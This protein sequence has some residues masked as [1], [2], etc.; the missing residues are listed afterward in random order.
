M[1]EHTVDIRKC[2]K[3]IHDE[4]RLAYY[5]V[6]Q[7]VSKQTKYVKYYCSFNWVYKGF[8]NDYYDLMRLHKELYILI[9]WIKFDKAVFF[10]IV[11]K[12]IKQSELDV[13][14]GVVNLNLKEYY[15]QERKN[16]AYNLRL[17]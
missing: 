6:S 15:K 16:Y 5:C 4:K 17:K 8:W 2:K 11:A 12:T 3:E 13:C 9:D 7:Y 1:S 10:M 14:L